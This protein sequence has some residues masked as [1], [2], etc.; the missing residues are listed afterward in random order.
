LWL[1]KDREVAPL[2]TDQIKM[3]VAHVQFMTNVVLSKGLYNL[4]AY[5]QAH[6]VI[7]LV[8]IDLFSSRTAP[9]VGDRVAAIVQ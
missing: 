8:D 7:R 1:R 5:G 2:S 6:P 3:L 9:N 4:G